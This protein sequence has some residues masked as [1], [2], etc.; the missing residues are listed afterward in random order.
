MHNKS[1][2]KGG[3][4]FQDRNLQTYTRRGLSSLRR[5]IMHNK[6]FQRVVAETNFLP[7]LAS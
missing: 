4:G 3:A 2:S 5:T 7:P 1:R 6:D